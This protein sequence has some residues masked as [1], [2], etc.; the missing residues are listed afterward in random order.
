M[1]ILYCF[2]ALVFAAV[3]VYTFLKPTKTRPPLPPGPPGYPVIGCL[4]QIVKNKPT[5]RWMNKIM[6][7]MNTEIACF[8]IGN[9]YVIPVTS[10]ELAREF[11]KKQDA[12]FASRPDCMSARIISSSYIATALSPLGDQWKK[13]RRVLVSEVLSPAMHRRLHEKRSQEADHLVRYVYNQTNGLV[14][15]RVAAQH[16][17]G[18]VIRKLVFGKRFFG[19]GAEDGGPGVE[20]REHLDGCFSLLSHLYA[21]AIGD[22]I[23]WL[24]IFDFDGYKKI[25]TNAMKHVSKYQDPEINQRVEM[26]QN[27]MRHGEED[28][29]DVLINLKDSQNNPML[30]IQEIKSQVLVSY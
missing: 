11:L 3:I 22:Y 9:T 1:E 20:E 15:V 4:P 19:P 2:L 12:V 17:C 14:N 24:E 25:L 27:G 10:P 26:W 8:P 16:F 29:L 5:F 18:N 6:T 13:M 7:E 28:I 23:P 30:S 21:F